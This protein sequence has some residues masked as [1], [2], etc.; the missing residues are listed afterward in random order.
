MVVEGAVE[1]FLPEEVA[2][3]APEDDDGEQ[4][5]EGGVQ[6]VFAGQEDEDGGDQDD[7][8]ALHLGRVGG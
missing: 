1:A 7:G 2:V 8:P 3:Q 4:G 6:F 5:D